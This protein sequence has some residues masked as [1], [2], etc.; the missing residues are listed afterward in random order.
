MAMRAP[1]SM[2]TPRLAPMMESSRTSSGVKRASRVVLCTF[3]MPMTSSPTT[4][5]TP[6]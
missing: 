1:F 3:K 5:G 6:R 4:I 2:A